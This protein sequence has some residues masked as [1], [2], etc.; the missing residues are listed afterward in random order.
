M[1]PTE[2]SKQVSLME[3]LKKEVR[4]M[5]IAA[6]AGL[7]P[8]QLE[9]QYMAMVCKPLPLR[10]LGFQSTLEL[11]TQMPEV[12]RICSSKNGT[13]ILKAIAD[14]STKGIARLVA[15]QKMK[16]RK[17]SKKT[18]MKANATF[19]TKN[20]KNP[21]SFQTLSAR[22][23]ILPAA[24][25][26]EL[27]D[28]LSSSPLLLTDLDKAFLSRFGRALQYRQYGF[29]SMF[30]V[31][32]SMSDSIVIEQTKAGSLVVLRKYLASQIEQKEVHQGE[33]EEDEEDEVPQGEAEEDEVPQG[34]AEEDE[35]KP[36]TGP[37]ERSCGAI[38]D[39]STKGIARLV[40]NQKMKT[41][42]A[43]KKTA[44]K[45]N[46]TFPTKNSKNPQSFQ[47]LSARTP[48]L[49][50]AVKAELQD[51]LSSSPLL[52]TDLDK[53]FLSRFGRALQ[54][55]QYGFLSMFEV[56]RSMSDSIV[57]EQTKAGSLVVLRKYLASQIEQKEV[58]QGEAEEDEEDEVPQGEAEE[59][60]VPQGEA[61]EDEV[62]QGE[63]EED[64]VPQG[65]AEEDE[66]PQGEA[67]EDEVPQGEA[68]EDEVPQGEAEEDEVPQGEA[69]EDEVPQG[70]A[71]ED[72]V[73]QGEAEEDEVPQ[74]EAEEDEV[75]QGEA[76]ED[77]VPRGEAGEEEKPQG[78]AEQEEM[79]QGEAEEEEMPQAACA[80]EVP[81]LG[82]ACE[83]QSI[84]QAALLVDS[85]PV[86]LGDHLE[87]HQGSEQLPP[88]PEIPLDAVQ[89]RSLCS[90]PPLKRRCLVGVI[91]EFIVSP[92]Q[93]YIHIC[94]KETSYKLQDLMLE[95]RHVYSH[96]VAADKYIM[97]ESAVR[98]GQLCCVM[99]CNWWYRVIIHRVINDQEVEVFYADYGHLQIVQKSWLRFLKWH[100]LNLPAQAIPCSLAWVKPVEGRWSSA[101][102]LLFKHLC[103]FKELVGVVDEY[104]DGVLYLF[105]CDTS[106]KDDVYFHSV[107]RDMG[108]ADVCGE[109]IPSQ[110]FG[111]LNPSALYVQP[112]GKQGNAG[113]VEPDLCL[114]QESQDEDS[115]TATL[116]LGR[117]EL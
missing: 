113:V 86:D 17:A 105:L 13:L 100:Y 110:E 77:E 95:M 9:E 106:T 18:A 107:L 67:E 49:P 53:A 60:E 83:I 84:H 93:F 47:T 101:A 23:P 12:V 39:D 6:K 28:L 74:G 44:M 14:D 117:A 94:S 75:P 81:P 70:E 102:V 73:P 5:L 10:D 37:L 79:A 35:P 103:R 87:Q 45:A 96:K 76:E 54:Y 7:T 88:T 40:A 59:D 66:V 82:P 56:L 112:S 30:E 92:S 72:E 25:K 65:E 41:R 29:L 108:Y 26:A 111:E 8:E 57:I 27:Q 52:L 68:E 48:I 38:A 71:E 50:A 16:T 85:E 62:P 114:Q 36:A 43:S 15:N 91:V 58:H 32:R 34:E 42:K 63:A 80:A 55:R 46:A 11:V 90:L 99:V 20:S 1:A 97:P 116:K 115:E 19:P 33:A 61:E 89:D 3:V 51:L 4:A 31:L 69:E 98:P 78:E 64:E 109:N 22:T 2:L 21:Q 104:V 24:V